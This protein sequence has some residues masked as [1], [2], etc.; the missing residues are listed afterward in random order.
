[1]FKDILF[2]SKRI[3]GVPSDINLDTMS[4]EELYRHFI[5]SVKRRQSEVLSSWNQSSCKLCFQRRRHDEADIHEA[6]QNLC[7]AI[8]KEE[9]GKW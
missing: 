3:L 9:S 4:K 1:M 8:G 6:F 5:E 7:K 2:K